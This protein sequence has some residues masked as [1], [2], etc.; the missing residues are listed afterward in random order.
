[1]NIIILILLYFTNNTM[2]SGWTKVIQTIS[3]NVP[4]LG[5]SGRFFGVQVEKSHVLS[6]NTNFYIRKTNPIMLRNENPY[7]QPTYM[8]NRAMVVYLMLLT[9]IRATAT[10]TIEFTNEIICAVA[11]SKHTDI[12]LTHLD[13]EV[14]ITWRI[15][16]LV[17]S[18]WQEEVISN[19]HPFYVYATLLQDT[20]MFKIAWGCY[21][22]IFCVEL[23][24]A[25][26]SKHAPQDVSPL[27]VRSANK[28]IK[29][30][31]SFGD[32]NYSLEMFAHEE[33]T[34]ACLSITRTNI[35]IR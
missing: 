25:N 27:L 12:P 1:M 22:M 33:D 26:K 15:L 35:T 28:I 14:T 16:G 29:S 17:Q 18:D 6:Q 2:S 10:K 13:M 7:K 23:K 9:Q 24:L 32:Q 34:E 20:H 11:R 19:A 31:D 21:N 4:F 3:K 30:S 8:Q 5:P